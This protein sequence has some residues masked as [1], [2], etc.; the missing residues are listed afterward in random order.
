MPRTPPSGGGQAVDGLIESILAAPGP[1]GMLQSVCA[2]AR[3]MTRAT[4]AAVLV[5][6]H[7]GVRAVATAEAETGVADGWEGKRPALP[8]PWLLGLAAAYG[9]MPGS[10]PQSVQLKAGP[11]DMEGFFVPILEQ[12][13]RRLS[14]A[15]CVLGASEGV[16]NSL[17][18]VRGLLLLAEKSA[19]SAPQAPPRMPEDQTPEA[20]D[21]QKQADTPLADVIH[22][23]GEVQHSERF[24]EAAVTFCAE[25]AAR[26]R[27]RR[28]AV[29]VVRAHGVKVVAIDQMEKFSRG[30]RSVRLLEDAL[31][32]CVEQNEVV[33][34][35]HGEPGLVVTDAAARL[36]RAEDL[37][38]V[39]SMPFKVHGE[40]R[41]AALFLAQDITDESVIKAFR[42]AGE[43][44]APRLHE[45]R[46]AE[47]LMPVRL[48][49]KVC[50][51]A[52]DLFG[53]RHTILKIAT[54]SVGLILALSLIIQ[55]DLIISAPLVIEGTY[56]YTHTAPMDSYLTEVLARPGDEV[57][58]GELLG[59]LDAT[60]IQLEIAALR[61]Q[62]EIHHSQS[63]QLRQEGREAEA[64]LAELESKKDAV[65]LEW[66]TARLAMTE[67]KSS[68]NGFVVSED[69]FPR[70][71]QPVRR[72]QEL[73]EVADTAS[74]RPTMHVDEHDIGDLA[75]SP[76]PEGYFALTAYPEVRVPFTVER[77][78]PLGAVVGDINGFE[79]RGRLGA[80][81]DG[82]LL[83]PG[84]EGYARIIAGRR[85]LFS[86]WTREI[87]NRLTLMWWKWL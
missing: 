17:L 8:P 38:C 20:S 70:L 21:G 43:L 11:P 53:P 7:T 51:A 59:R 1:A 57:R 87:M 3:T 31:L 47:A 83:R 60:E 34:H 29:G 19:T 18:L 42:L 26:L 12:Q 80:L 77:V 67:L 40:V 69:M 30:T 39:V 78:H 84:M 81:P 58:A 22:I 63:F 62:Q 2:L 32:E 72:G 44:A 61:A 41:F 55:G 5:R 25:T 86:I 33:R 74:L 66:A 6:D 10:T 50:M 36:A 48:W 82:I 27:L 64:A 45:L 79:V 13:D 71:G 23:L 37:P 28:V 54:L 15:V 65:N 56:S 73:F 46:M 4:G 76:P 14:L 75:L 49:R 24:F 68:V 9:D 85:S 52:A 16:M 35:P